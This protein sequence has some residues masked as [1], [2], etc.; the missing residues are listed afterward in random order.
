MVV[1]MLTMV[2]VLMGIVIVVFMSVIMMS[3]YLYV[4]Q[5]NNDTANYNSHN[6]TFVSGM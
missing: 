1:M 6:I 4:A 2:A 5:H 3:T